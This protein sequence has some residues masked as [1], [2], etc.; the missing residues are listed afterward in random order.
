KARLA[1]GVDLAAVELLALVLVAHD[2]VGGIDLGKARSRLRIVLVVVRVML[3][4]KL[5]IGTLDRRGAGAPRHP[6]DLIGVTHPSGLL[7]GNSVVG[8]LGQFVR[9]GFI[10]GAS[11]IFATTPKTSLEKDFT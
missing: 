7:H 2:L 10:W 3:L 8:S 11:C 5:A 9:F 6:Q 4:G 1:I